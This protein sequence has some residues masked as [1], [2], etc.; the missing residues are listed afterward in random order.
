MM[1][2]LSDGFLGTTVKIEVQHHRR[3][4]AHGA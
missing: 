1:S 2:I 4:P 3:F